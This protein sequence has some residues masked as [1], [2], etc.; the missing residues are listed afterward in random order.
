VNIGSGNTYPA[1]ALSIFKIKDMI[2]RYHLKILGYNGHYATSV[3]ANEYDISLRQMVF[4]LNNAVC[5]VYPVCKTI[6]EEIEN[7]DDN[8]DYKPG[9]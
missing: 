8:T 3:D 7:L 6:I 2:K 9:Y 5:A 4:Y 1:N